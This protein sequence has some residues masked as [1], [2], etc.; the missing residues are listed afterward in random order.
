MSHLNLPSFSLKS[1]PLVL[2][3]SDN[4]ESQSPSCLHSP[5]V[6][7]GHNEVALEPYLLQAEQAQLPHCA[8]MGEVLQPCD[9][10]HGSPL[11]LLQQLHMLLVLGTPGLNTVL[12]M[13]PWQ[14][15][16]EGDSLSLSLVPLLF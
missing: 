7:E 11:D 16:T 4:V 1:F 10:P 9:N 6:L 3:L 13:G 8:F 12:Q 15:R 5:L 2:S 14:G